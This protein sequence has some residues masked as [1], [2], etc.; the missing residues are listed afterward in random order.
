MRELNDISFNSLLFSFGIA[1]QKKRKAE[2]ARQKYLAQRREGITDAITAF[3]DAFSKL[4]LSCGPIGLPAEYVNDAKLVPLYAI[5]EVLSAQG[6]VLHEQEM[7]LKIIFNNFNPTYNY[8][9]YTQAVINRTGIYEA[10][11]DIVGLE[12]NKCGSFWLTL[13][14]LFY[15]TRQLDTL[16][17]IDDQLSLI[18]ANF[19]FLGDSE[20]PFPEA[21]CKRILSILNKHVSTYQQ[22]PYIHALLLLQTIL[23]EQRNLIIEDHFLL[24]DADIVQDD[25]TYYVFDVYQKAIQVFCGRFAVRALNMVDGQLDLKN[26]MDIIML[27]DKDKRKYEVIF[28]E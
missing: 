18:V 9:Q 12:E 2:Q 20:S 6:A 25:R 14:E 10:Y 28:Q 26:D 24:R 21:I 4:V 7:V 8:S 22:T 11:W 3:Q 23:L 19:A 13:F 27:W 1:A 15:R 16:Q 17:A 5:G